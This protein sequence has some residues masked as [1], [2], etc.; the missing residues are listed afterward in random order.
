MHE[1]DEE[2]E[3]HNIFDIS[4]NK[5]DMFDVDRFLRSPIDSRTSDTSLFTAFERKSPKNSKNNGISK[6]DM[7]MLFDW[8]KKLAEISQ[9][10]G[11]RDIKT[12]LNHCSILERNIKTVSR[13]RNTTVEDVVNQRVEK[14]KTV[15]PVQLKTKVNYRRISDTLSPKRN[16][17]S[18]VSSILYH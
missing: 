1:T 2:V 16:Y 9:K 18:P 11:K 15:A 6:K 8:G 17:R 4:E 5:T 13:S 12:R 3:F 7:N 10:T 14:S